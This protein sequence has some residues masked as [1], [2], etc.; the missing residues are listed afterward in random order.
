MTTLVRTRQPLQV[1][2]MSHH[3]PERRKSKRLAGTSSPE[4]EEPEFKRRK[5]TAAPA[6]VINES[7]AFSQQQQQHAPAP[8]TGRK[9]RKNDADSKG[10]S[11]AAAPA[12]YDEQDGDFLFTRGSKRVKTTPAPA[13]PPPPPEP[14]PEP[15]LPLPKMST[16]KKVGRPPKNS[17]KKRASSPAQQFAPPPPLPVQPQQQVLPRRTSKRRSSAAA[18][19]AP[20]PVQDEEPVMPKAKTRRKGRESNAD[21]KAR[22]EAQRRQLIEGIPEEEEEDEAQDQRHKHH[23]DHDHPMTNGT[24]QAEHPSGAASQMI[25]LPFSDTPIQNRNKEFRKKGGA[26]GG[27][28]SSL[29]M[30]GR[31]ASSLIDNG[32]SALPHREVDP[33]DFYKYISAEGLS[34]PRRMKQ[35]L[36]WC[37]ERALSEKPRGGKGNSAVLGARAIQD[38]ILKDFS[39]VSEFSDWF[40]RE[41]APKP[42][43]VLKPNPRNEDYDRK[44][45]EMEERIK[46]LKEVKKAWQAIAKPLPTLD[47][48]YPLSAPPPDNPDAPPQPD[49]RK[50]PLPDPNLLS[51]EETKMLTFLTSPETSFGSWK[52]QVRSRLQNVHQELEFEVDVLADRVHKFDMRVETAG[53]EADQV[54]RLG[55]ERLREREER[56]KERVGTRGVGVWEVL[57]SL[58]RILPEGG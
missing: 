22:E 16:A 49:P 18:Q 9:K 26:S 8:A 58:G 31:R 7:A 39:S 1:L 44:I 53:R 23:R 37:G 42:P 6:A 50:A 47:P 28:R 19:A 27:R 12:V 41:E 48:I 40:S 11:A 5:R 54:L 14:E 2:S 34:E 10:S 46:R 30:R 56:E 21:K 13:P 51:E 29:G 36:I 24:P 25:S 55:A 15:E 32:Q 43:V 45:E 35:L 20:Q 57:R 38:Q 52:R 33:K 17:S 3:Q 4:P